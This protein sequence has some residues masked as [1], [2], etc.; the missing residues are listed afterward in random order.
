MYI[1]AKGKLVLDF[2]Q[3]SKKVSKREIRG[4]RYS[5]WHCAAKK[6][7][8]LILTHLKDV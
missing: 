3:K 4:E 7:F 6:I 5:R 8:G 1:L 2:E